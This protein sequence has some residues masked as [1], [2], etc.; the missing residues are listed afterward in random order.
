M[1]ALENSKFK[2]QSAKRETAE[3][4]PVSRRRFS[5]S[6]FCILHFAFLVACATEAERAPE[7]PAPVRIGAENVITVKRDTIVVGPIISGELRAQREANVRAEIGGSV[8][9]V[10]VE[11]GQAV[12][13]G[14][15][16]GRIEM[17]TL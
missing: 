13:R 2:M 9:Q 17:R 16:L 1:T 8:T 14:A 5:A 4:R 7:A 3:M 12:R 11:E 6:A 15:L 10:A